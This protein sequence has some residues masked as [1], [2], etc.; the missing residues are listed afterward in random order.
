L[1]TKV[2]PVADLVD[3]LATEAY[4]P[5]H[6]IEVIV[7]ALEPDSWTC[8][9]GPGA[10]SY[11]P[12][13]LVVSQ[14][15]HVQE[16]IA[17]LLEQLR[18][19]PPAQTAGTS[20]PLTRIY[21]I[22]GAE[23]EPVAKSI[24]ATV[25]PAT[26]AGEGENSIQA[27]AVAPSDTAAAGE[28]TQAATQPAAGGAGVAQSDPTSPKPIDARTGWLVVRNEGPVHVLVT[29]YLRDLGILR[30]KPQQVAERKQPQFG[31]FAPPQGP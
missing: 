5:D 8:G 3:R 29:R 12:G 21:E 6:L 22:A 19:V 4:E 31:E 1:T 13:A 14:P 24:E 18:E 11:V 28:E 23:P 16:Q 30:G 26:W 25:A 17:A 10:I 15:F 2:Y 7:N 20:G 9:G 27:L